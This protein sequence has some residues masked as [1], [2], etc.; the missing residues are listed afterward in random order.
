MGSRGPASAANPQAR[1]RVQAGVIAF[2]A[3]VALSLAI[4]YALR[5]AIYVSV[6]GTKVPASGSHPLIATLFMVA[7][8]LLI[9]L[10]VV[11]VLRC[12]RWVFWLLVLA[13][14]ASALQVPAG[15]LELAGMLPSPFPA[16]YTIYRSLVAV[17]EV[18]LGVWLLVVWR[19][20]GVWAAGR[21]PRQ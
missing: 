15:A 17:A 12:W 4:I 6:L 19:R 5:P 9:A 20:W 7:I 3:V 10:L 11:G 8:L 14:T 2:F 1:R 16:W 21:R 18:G 13:F